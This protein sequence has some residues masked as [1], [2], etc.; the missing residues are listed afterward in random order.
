MMKTSLI[1]LLALGLLA[2]SC[3]HKK[4]DLVTPAAPAGTVAFPQQLAAGTWIVTFYMQATEDKTSQLAGY[5]FAFAANGQATAS[6]SS[7]TDP[8]SWTWGGNS[9]YG[10]PAD[11]KTV[12]FTFGNQ[13]PLDR[14]S[15]SWIIASADDKVIK[16]DSSNP[17]EQEHLTLGR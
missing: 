17:A 2:A 6:H 8:G 11:S 1:S 13:R 10:T 5:R 3:N 12:V 15:K 14:I 9:Y 4:D 16:L 7:S